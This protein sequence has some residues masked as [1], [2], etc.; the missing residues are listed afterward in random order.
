ME[1]SKSRN[2]TAAPKSA[3]R[4]LSRDQNRKLRRAGTPLPAPTAMPVYHREFRER[5]VAASILGAL[6][7]KS[8]LRPILSAAF[9]FALALGMPMV[10]SANPCGING[11]R[12]CCLFEAPDPCGCAGCGYSTPCTDP[13]GCKCPG[14]VVD[15][16]GMCFVAPPCGG[17][18]QR[19]CC[20]GAGEFAPGGGACDT[21]LVQLSAHVVKTTRPLAFAAPR[22]HL[23]LRTLWESAFGPRRAAAR[24]N[25]PVATALANSPLMAWPVTPAR[26]NFSAHVAQTNR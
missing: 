21:G 9:L 18:G 3:G 20:N 1:E 17:E 4:S 12:A 25:E 26:C 6:A 10:S 2:A 14:G 22:D 16:L 7:P 24:G 5:A 19:A 13:T 8:G 11:T 15:D 23:S